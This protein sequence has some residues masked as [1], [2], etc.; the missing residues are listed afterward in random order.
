ME[1]EQLRPGRTVVRVREEPLRLARASDVA[2]PLLADPFTTASLVVDHLMTLLPWPDE[3]TSRARAYTGA[4]EGASSA[5]STGRRP[6]GPG[7][8][9]SPPDT[10]W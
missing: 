10:L 3:T 8:S 4:G 2:V 7:S 6:A 5:S 1:I 9:P